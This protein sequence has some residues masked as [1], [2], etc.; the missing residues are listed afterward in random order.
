[1]LILFFLCRGAFSIVKRCIHKETRKEFAA[2]IFNTKKLSARG[3]WTFFCCLLFFYI[4]SCQFHG[5]THYSPVCFSTLSMDWYCELSALRS[6]LVLSGIPKGSV[7]FGRK[8]ISGR[9]HIRG[10]L[11]KIFFFTDMDRL[12]LFHT[13]FSMYVKHTG[14]VKLLP[15]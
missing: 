5:L 12:T 8:N 15:P 10:R 4:I 2:K 7:F 11:E 6:R 9:S 3:R 1:M 13:G 14:V